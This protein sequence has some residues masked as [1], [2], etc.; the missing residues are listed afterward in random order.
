MKPSAHSVIRLLS[1][2]EPTELRLPEMPPTF[3]YAPIAGSTLTVWAAAGIVADAARARR[4]IQR[5]ISPF[6]FMKH[7]PSLESSRIRCM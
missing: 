2:S 1:V 5:F 4:E 6:P 7:T 3:S